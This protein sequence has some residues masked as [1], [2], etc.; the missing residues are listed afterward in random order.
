M[1][2]RTTETKSQGRPGQTSCK[3]VHKANLQS[4][5]NFFYMGS[6]AR[7]CPHPNELTRMPSND[8]PERFYMAARTTEIKP[9]GRA[10]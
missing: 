9:Q 10:G 8:P 7:V 1:G 2:A 4:Q 3:N 5:L 6:F